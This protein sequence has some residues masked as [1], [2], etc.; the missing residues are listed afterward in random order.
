MPDHHYNMLGKIVR[1]TVLSKP[2]GPKTQPPHD[3]PR[4]P[5]AENGRYLAGSVANCWACHTQRDPNTGA[6][7]GALYT[8]A[9]NFTDEEN[10]KRTWAPPNLTSALSTGRLARFTGNAFVARFRAGRAIPGSPMPWQGFAR[11]SDDDLRAIY[12]F[13]KTVPAVENDVGPAVVEK[14]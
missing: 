13:L 14:R 11:M 1:A 5:T 2:V 12:R 9:N 8:G 7:T 4:G 10:P 3:S 6:L